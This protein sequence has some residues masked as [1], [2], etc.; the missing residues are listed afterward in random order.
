[1]KILKKILKQA[2]F[3]VLVCIFGV[4][5]GLIFTVLRFTG[6]VKVKGALP[7]KWERGLL[8]VSNHP[9]LLETVLIPLLFFPRILFN[10]FQY[11]PWSTPDRRNFEN[12]TTR[13]YLRWIRLFPVI[14][15]ERGQIV[16]AVQIHEFVERVVRKL[17]EKKAVVIFPEGGRTSS[18]KIE[19][20]SRKGKKM[21]KLKSG[22][23]KI[24]AMSNC[25]TV[26]LWID[27]TEL[28]LPRGA[29]IPKFL[30][31]EEIVIK[32]G[33]PIIRRITTEEVGKILLDLADN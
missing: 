15:V 8:L 4:V 31:A 32:I 29:R 14:P 9:S 11:L 6:K 21:R 23:S 12:F 2:A 13:W 7:K 25:L 28:V 18:G 30:R 33:K 5:L 17:K 1:M 19:L 10:P 26:P 16:T 3:F 27:K 24:I 22:V 20:I